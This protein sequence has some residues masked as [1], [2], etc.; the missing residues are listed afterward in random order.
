MAST[1]SDY[2]DYEGN[3]LDSEAL[4]QDLA[5]IVAKEMRG[6][7]SHGDG[8]YTSIVTVESLVLRTGRLF[9]DV[10]ISV[11][12]ADGILDDGIV[13]D[14]ENETVSTEVKWEAAY[15]QPYELQLGF[16]PEK[17]EEALDKVANEWNTYNPSSENDRVL[18]V[19]DMGSFQ[20]RDLSWH[21]TL[22][23]IG[24]TIA[25][26]AESVRQEKH[27]KAFDSQGTLWVHS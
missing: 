26:E 18:E 12:T 13:V 1:I 24:Q 10:I 20:L 14:V 25:N 17:L 23:A 19:E 6:T 3:Y 21:T 27:E 9:F 7:S 15:M 5:D 16:G 22:E 4:S 2:Y 8:Y 11:G